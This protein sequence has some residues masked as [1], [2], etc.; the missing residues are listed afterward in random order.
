M[1]WSQVPDQ[2]SPT[3]HCPWTE[4][5]LGRSTSACHMHV[6]TQQVMYVGIRRYSKTLSI[7]KGDV[8]FLQ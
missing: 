8:P 2:Y 4:V 5:N 3:K 7:V 1:A 6:S